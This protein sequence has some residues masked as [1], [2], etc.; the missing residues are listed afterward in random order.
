MSIKNYE[1][2]QDKFYKRCTGDKH[3]KPQNIAGVKLRKIQREIHYN[4]GS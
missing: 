3:W 2:P 1:R 4:Y